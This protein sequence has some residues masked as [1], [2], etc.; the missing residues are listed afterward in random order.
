MRIKSF[1]VAIASLVAVAAGAPAAAQSCAG[2]T[3]VLSSN[4]FCPNVEW[5][6]NR[7]ITT[8]CTST[9][10]YCP[11]DPV[12]RLSMA[13]FMNRLGTALTPIDLAPASAAGAV[14]NPTLNPVVCPT[15]A[16]GFAVTGFPRRAYVN[17]AAHLSSPNA[18]VDIVASIVMSTNNGASWTGVANTSHY[19]TLY[20]GATPAQHVS[21]APFGWVDLAV[22]QTVRFGIGI[23][24]FAGTGTGIT[25]AC[26]LAVQIGNRNA[27]VSPLDP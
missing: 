18:A 19:A 22:G 15:A 17:G 23:T 9:T 4:G 5:L 14:L 10:V 8:G 11:N 20:S 3:D 16:P 21:L 25:I 7:A 12:T 24:R 27:S 13:A 26:D 6:K 2:F 1:A